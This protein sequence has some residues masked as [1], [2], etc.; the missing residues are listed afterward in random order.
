MSNNRK[1]VVVTVKQKLQLIEMSEKGKSTSKLSEEYG[2][3]AQTVR[4]IIKQK[5]KLEV[6]TRDCDSNAGPSTRKTMKTSSYKDLDTAMLQW[7]NQKRAEGMPITGSV[8]AHKAKFFHDSLGLEDDFNASS[9]WLTRFKK[10]HGIHQLS[11]QGERLSGDVDAAAKFRI[12]FE[13]YVQVNDLT[14]D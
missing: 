8:I 10:R 2:V 7:F 14:P 1:R 5:R 11:I 6:F 4:D 12:E 3:G 9:G 13:E